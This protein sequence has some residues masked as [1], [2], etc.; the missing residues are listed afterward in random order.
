L[1]YSGAF[2]EALI[3]LLGCHH[4]EVICKTCTAHVDVHRLVDEALSR[5]YGDLVDDLGELVARGGTAEGAARII[6]EVAGRHRINVNHRPLPR[7]TR[8]ERQANKVKE[9]LG[10]PPRR[11]LG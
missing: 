7:P 11:R 4:D 3:A 9:L 6:K 2:Q 5:F 1:N 10:R 8:A